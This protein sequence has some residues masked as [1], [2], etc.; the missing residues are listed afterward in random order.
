[1][2][3]TPFKTVWDEPEYTAYYNEYIFD[4]G[5]VMTL[6]HLDVFYFSA[7]ILRQMLRQWEVFREHN[8][9]VLFCHG[10]VDDEKFAK[11]VSK[12]G[13]KPL[14]VVPCSDGVNRRLFV[15]FGPEKG[16]AKDF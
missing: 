4:T 14:K 10:E 7:S 8:P 6:F 12:F 3:A 13:F 16:A 1:M 11:F 15:N 5:E 2:E 9:V